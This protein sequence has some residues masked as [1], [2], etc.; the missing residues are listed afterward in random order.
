MQ[1]YEQFGCLGF[2]PRIYKKKCNDFKG[3][4]TPQKIKKVSKRVQK[5][6]AYGIMSMWLGMS[7]S[8]IEIPRQGD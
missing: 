5:E 7:P 6:H 1:P 4:E 2:A 3:L 8:K